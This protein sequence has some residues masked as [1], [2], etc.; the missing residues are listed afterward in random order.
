MNFIPI[1]PNPH[2]SAIMSAADAKIETKPEAVEEPKA[3]E[4]TKPVQ[5]AETTA[6]ETNEDTKPVVA[7]CCLGGAAKL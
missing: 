6:E 1:N 7:V 5:A 3:V 2:T 4:E